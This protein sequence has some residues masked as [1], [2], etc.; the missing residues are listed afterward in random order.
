[1]TRHFI[2]YSTSDAAEF[3]ARLC[4]ELEAGHPTVPVW[5]DKRDVQP[6]QEWDE[7]VSEAI[8]TCLSL[9]FVMTLDSVDD[10]S[11]CKGEWTRALRY[12]KPIIPVKLHADAELPLRLDP[13]N[14]VDFTRARDSEEEYNAAMARLR[15]R[16]VWL[17]SPEGVLESM[18]DR[19]ADAQRDLRR[20]QDAVRRA[21]VE[22][23]IEQLRK[24]IARQE[25]VVRDPQ[26]AQRRVEESIARGLERERQPPRAAPETRRAKFIN[27]PPG[28]SPSYFQDRQMETGT[29]A[30]F[31]KDES[32]RLITVIGRGGTGKTALVCRLLKSVEGGQ[33]PDG[34]GPLS[35][36][37]IVYLS[38][39]GTRRVNTPNIYADLCRLLPEETAQQLDALYKN[40]Q[41]S[42]EL[43]MQSLLAHFGEGRVVVLLDNFEDVINRETHHVLDEELD[44]ALRALL[45]LPHHAVKVIVT[46]RVAPQDLAL[47]Q[48]GRQRPLHLDEG[49]PSPYAENI[50]REMDADGRVGL[51]TSPDELL[52]EARERTRGY[53]RA[54]EA[55]FAILAADRDTTLSDI[56]RDT[57]KLLP[58]N[59]VH[60][61]V[62]EAFSRLDPAAQKVMQALAVYGHPV[63]PAA[64]DYLLQPHQPGID[65]APVLKRLVNMQFARRES[66]RYYLHRVDRAYALARVPRGEPSD[67]GEAGAPPY[68]QFA[69]LHRG[70]EYFKE[71]RLPAE[72]W[73][74]VED[75]APQLAEFDLRCAGEDYDA[76]A[77]VLFQIDFEYLWTWGFYRRMAEMHERLQGKLSDPLLEQMSV[78]NL[79]IAYN[80]VGQVQKAVACY[81][82][83]IRLS[84][85]NRNR[86]GEGAWLSNLGNCYCH[87]GDTVLAAD[88]YVQALAIAREVGDRRLEASILDN[89]GICKNLLGQ[90]PDAITY[91]EQALAICRETGDRRSQ[92]NVLGNFVDALIGEHRYAEA[93][94][95]ALEGVAI[96]EELNSPNLRSF[97]YVNL[98]QARF[99]AGDLP[100]AREAAETACRYDEPSN[101]HFVSALL[102]LILLRQGDVPAARD[103]FASAVAQADALLTFSKEN[104]RALYSKALALCGLALCGDAGRA[105]EAAGAYRAARAINKDAGIRTRVLLLFDTLAEA[106]VAGVLAGVRKAAAGEE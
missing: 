90:T 85:D 5:L 4:D 88:Y 43:K 58:E 25:E 101:N 97:N 52:G 53:P 26:A 78:G 22:D 106:D 55:L 100:G 33:L 12:K 6:G 62:G 42:T 37:G 38:A 87:V 10:E 51:R 102:G 16:L 70:A 50:L 13:R 49:L 45:N 64:V 48:P 30:S 68:T 80:G 32:V 95:R 98:A 29:L 46:T 84:R 103:A 2:C 96:A 73:K 66:G 14:Y 31:L 19:L 28:L 21:R 59:V 18:K 86:P 15:K 57:V 94:E 3:A 92:G 35:V 67:R 65:S 34:G 75:L 27:P 1:M 69:L 72:K 63:T 47:V 71:T 23:D 76:A 7:E 83:A 39:A 60:D 74:T 56:L 54:L 11:E 82:R 17:G 36:D 89:L 20:A 41:A 24:D 81:E 99:Y 79:G 77:H 40:P 91:H 44:E 105:G 8:K 104:L 9:I 93:I 61:L